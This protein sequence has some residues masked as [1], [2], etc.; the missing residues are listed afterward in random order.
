[1]AVF[2]I[3]LDDELYEWLRAEAFRRRTSM[4]RLIREAVTA[5]RASEAD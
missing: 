3:R 2:N 1:M 4:S 5:L